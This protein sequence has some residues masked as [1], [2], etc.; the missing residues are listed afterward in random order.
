MQRY[1]WQIVKNTASV[2]RVLRHVLH[3]IQVLPVRF[4]DGLPADYGTRVPTGYTLPFEPES[5]WAHAERERA[6]VSRSARP[7]ALGRE[8]Q[9]RF[10]KQTL[11]EL[12]RYQLRPDGSFVRREYIHPAQELAPIPDAVLTRHLNE[13]YMRSWH[14]LRRDRY[15]AYCSS[16]VDFL[17]FSGSPH[18]HIFDELRGHKRYE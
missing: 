11:Q 17:D 5:A 12:M 13:P 10:S 4:P 15:A 1:E 6:A 14:K 2:N 3:A 16:F 9:E 8:V 7:T 18:L